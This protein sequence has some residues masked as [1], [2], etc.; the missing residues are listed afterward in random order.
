MAGG[1]D[2]VA[3]WDDP[4]YIRPSHNDFRYRVAEPDK[5]PG[6]RWRLTG[7]HVGH[8]IFATLQIIAKRC[9]AAGF[10]GMSRSR[11]LGKT[12]IGLRSQP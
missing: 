6:Q 9:V 5:A 7:M 1:H 2:L 8:E 11:D 10:E 12:A 4:A 3:V